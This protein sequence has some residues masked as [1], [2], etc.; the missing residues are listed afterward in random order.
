MT[1][2][3]CTPRRLARSVGLIALFATALMIGAAA[4]AFAQIANANAPAVTFAPT[5]LK[6]QNPLTVKDWVN[7]PEMLG[8]WGGAR[9]KMGERGFKFKASWTQ[10]FMSSPTSQDERGWDYG[11][12]LDFKVTHDFTNM[13]WEGVSGTA[14]VEFRYGDVPLLA[15]GTLMPT[16]SALLFP[17]RE[18]SA[19]K[20]SSFYLSKM[21]GTS[22]V[23]SGGRFNLVDLYDKT[24]TGGE[25]LDKFNNLAFVVPP[26]YARTMPPVAEGVFFTTLKD[27]K[28]LV[29]VGLF[30]STEPGF[31]KNG[32]TFFASVDLP[33]KL[34]E[35][36]G[37]YTVTAT[38]SSI[39]ATSLDQ[40]PW[41]FIP[42]F[43]VPLATE[44]NAWTFDF[45]FDQYLWW[46]PAT[47]TG[48][49]VFGMIGA[50]DS[51]PSP[52]DI[53][54]HVGIGGNSPIPNR[55]QD[56]FGVGYYFGGVS[57]TLIDSLS[58]FVRLRDENGGELFYNFAITGWSKV[59]ADFQ[60][61]DP[62]V[63]GSKTRTFFSVRW[64][65][66]F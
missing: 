63:V 39:V 5:T 21:F 12:K 6:T 46:D 27:Q 64:K 58:P 2:T 10:F 43:D 7:R 44:N 54:G 18:G 9:T 24:F 26:L 45:T 17:D 49:G 60:F 15:G 20:V 51:N 37:H 19:A 48:F 57:N 31:F 23:L 42:A 22:A 28:P 52:F 13:G 65:L 11:G 38:A 56:N 8:D 53:F 32:A 55:S 61:I 33:L 4:P 16:I 29:T 30:E 66:T 35:T 59:T 34:F 41:A 62:F 36:P 50:S 25:G 1:H 3:A 40:T 14:H 47:K